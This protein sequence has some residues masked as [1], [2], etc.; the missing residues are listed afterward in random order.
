M[1]KFFILGTCS[2]LRRIKYEMI[3]LSYGHWT[4]SDYA[5]YYYLE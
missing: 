4:G 5:R 1:I 3:I 2:A